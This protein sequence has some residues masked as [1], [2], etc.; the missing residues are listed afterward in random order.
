MPL[1]EMRQEA[2]IVGP[3]REAKYPFGTMN[4]GDTFYVPRGADGKHRF[5]IMY[6]RRAYWQKKFPDRRWDIHAVSVGLR[7]QRVE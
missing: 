2:I 7:V 5:G 1:Y 4:V 6:T 3:G